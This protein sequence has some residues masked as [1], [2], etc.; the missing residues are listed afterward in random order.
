MPFALYNTAMSDACI[1]CGY[2]SFLSEI[3]KVWCTISRS[4]YIWAKTDPPCSAVSLR[5][6]SYLFLPH[7]VHCSTAV[8][9]YICSLDISSFS[10]IP[11]VRVVILVLPHL[12]PFPSNIQHL[13]C[14]DCLEDKHEDCQHCSVLYCGCWELC[15]HYTSAVSHLERLVNE[16]TCYLSTRTLNPAHSHLT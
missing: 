13:S 4:S 9:H 15:N 3:D 10:F 14:D 16:V 8:L 12:R 1:L 5:Q 11:Y 2:L 6:L 7:I